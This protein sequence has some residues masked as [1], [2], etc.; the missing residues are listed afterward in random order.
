MCVYPTDVYCSG[1]ETV[2]GMVT[3]ATLYKWCEQIASGM[4]YLALK[5]V[6]TFF[7]TGIGNHY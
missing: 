5:E 1:A 2:D 7:G 6:T 4:E 3:I